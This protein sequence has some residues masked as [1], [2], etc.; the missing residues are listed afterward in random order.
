MSKKRKRISDR[1]AKRM[2]QLFFPTE[3][4]KNVED[5]ETLCKEQRVDFI[6]FIGQINDYYLGISSSK[7][8]MKIDPD[9]MKLC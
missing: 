9:Q 1:H 8:E 7:K 4:Y 6:Q 3:R 2:S 5:G